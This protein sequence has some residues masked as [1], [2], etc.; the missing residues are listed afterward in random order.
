MYISITV[1]PYTEASISPEAMMHFPSVSDSLSP[2][3]CS[4]TVENFSN[5]YLF[6]KKIRFSSAKISDDLL[7]SHRLE[8]LKFL[9][10]PIFP[11]FQY[12]SPLF[13]ENYYFPPLHFKISPCFRKSYVFLHTLCV[14]CFPLVLP[15]CIYASNNART[16][17]LWPYTPK[18]CYF[19]LP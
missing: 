16:G 9:I 2:K 19:Y 8:I 10:F 1:L 5:F 3:N 18:I 4:D 15:W 6:T 14:F 11:L 7:F 12:I 17:R 13:R